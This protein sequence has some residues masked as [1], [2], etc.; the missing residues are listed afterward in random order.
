MKKCVFLDRDGTINREVGYLCEVENLEILENVVEGLRLLQ[1]EYLLIVI[2][3]Q[4]GVARGYFS[5]TKVDR[6]NAEITKRLEQHNV[7]IQEFF[8]CPHHPEGIVK[9]YAKV[10]DCRKPNIGLIER[11]R[12]KYD[13]DI[14]KSYMIGDKISDLLLAKNA[15][16]K[17]IFVKTGYDLQGKEQIKQLSDYIS[18][19]LLEAAE[20]ILNNDRRNK[21]GREL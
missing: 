16:C 9:E 12:K 14:S 21:N 11:A 2:S 18:D 10:C 1:Q 15:G 6:I 19:S 13:V 5:E 4:S 3:N 8:Y 17:G 20:W 7:F